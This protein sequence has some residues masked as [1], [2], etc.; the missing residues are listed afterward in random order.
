MVKLGL[1]PFHMF[2]EVAQKPS[3]S[4]ERLDIDTIDSSLD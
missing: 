2:I 4:N 1:S 3:I